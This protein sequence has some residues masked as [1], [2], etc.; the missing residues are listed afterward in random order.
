MGFLSY[1]TDAFREVRDSRFEVYDFGDPEAFD[2]SGERKRIDKA[3]TSNS[4]VYAIVNR[5]ARNAAKIPRKL[6]RQ[7]R[8][9]AWELVESGDLFEIVTAQPNPKQNINSFVEESITNLLLKGEIF[10]YG[11]KLIGFGSAFQGVYIL[12]NGIIR[13]VKV[14]TENYRPVPTA[15]IVKIGDNEQTIKAELVNHVLYYNPSLTFLK[16]YRGLS[17]LEAGLLPLIASQDNKTGQSVMVR[18]GAPRGLITSKS[19]RAM[20]NEQREQ[21]QKASDERLLGARKFGKAI[22]TSANVDFVKMGIDPAQLKMLEMAIMSK[23]DLCDIYAVDSSL[24]NDPANKT[25][26]NRKEAEKAF[27][28]NAVI[29]AN[30]KDIDGLSSWLLPEWEKKDGTRY[31]IEQDLSNITALHEDN[32]DKALRQ[33]KINKIIL[34]TLAA[35]ISDTQK[36]NTL[37]I[38]LDIDE[39]EAR[40]IVAANG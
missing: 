18:N 38:S 34:L 10:R 3:F 15:Y 2:P 16:K 12:N 11:E 29:P 31:L 28:T 20:T 5:I 36:I 19:E 17:P 24:F 4:D 40:Q 26:N 6:Y 23:R 13:D 8:E 37:M 35:Q 1:F 30:Q 25:Y 14:K 9:G 21:V 7:N 32:K 22:V 27:F 39:A 33:E